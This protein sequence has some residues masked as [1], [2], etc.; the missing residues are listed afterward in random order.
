MYFENSEVHLF[1]I[2][3]AGFASASLSQ[4]DFK[5]FQFNQDHAVQTV[6]WTDG[7]SSFLLLTD[8]DHEG[9]LQRFLSRSAEVEDL[10]VASMSHSLI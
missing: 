3:Q 10:A 7:N 4:P 6:S 9:I 8:E 2:D 5:I 1:V